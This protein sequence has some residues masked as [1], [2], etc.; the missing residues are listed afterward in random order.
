MDCVRE[1]DQGLTVS[2]TVQPRASKNS[3]AGVQGDLLKIRLTAP[4]VEGAANKMCIEF[5]AKSLGVTKS[6]IEILSGH[7]G[8][9]KRILLKTT[10]KIEK[11]RLIEK[12]RSVVS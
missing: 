12:I 8:R 2:L 6:S 1:I 3:I 9:K 10:D 11:Q 5:L 7:T 4:P